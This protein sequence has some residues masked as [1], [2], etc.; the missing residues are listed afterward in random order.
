MEKLT[1]NEV[2][3]LLARFIGVNK[4][5]LLGKVK[6]VDK[7]DNTCTV[8][9]ENID[10]P[11]IRLSSVTGTNNG[12]IMYPKVGS[13]ILC[14]KVEDTEE[15]S[16]LLASE[17]DSIEIKIDSLVINGGNLGGLVVSQKIVDEMEKQ[18][19][20]IN[21][22]VTSLNSLA[23]A[24]TATAQAPV[25]GAALGTAITSAIGGVIN[26]LVVPQPTVFENDKIKH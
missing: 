24:M 14:V 3:L 26:P 4:P 25:L 22:I 1:E 21:D 7:T 2:R 12:I 6:E 19:N 8:T 9:D 11:G 15:Y 10:I 5:T 20:R 13:F 18:I 23:S 16:M 17:Y